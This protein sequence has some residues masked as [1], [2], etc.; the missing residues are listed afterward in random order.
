VGREPDSQERVLR[1]RPK[2]LPAAQIT[3]EDGAWRW[4]EE[5]GSARGLALNSGNSQQTL[6]EPF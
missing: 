1:A 2:P 4:E 5:E 6:S 3:E